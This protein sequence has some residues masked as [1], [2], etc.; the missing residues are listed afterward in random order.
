MQPESLAEIAAD[1]ARETG[2]LLRAMFATDLSVRSKGPADVVSEADHAAQELIER[3]LLEAR[4]DDGL[5]G[6]ED[7]ARTGSTGLRWVIDP[8]DGTANYLH[9]VPVWCVSIGCE[10]GDGPLAGAVYDAC[11]DE[12]FTAARGRG[13]RVDGEP[14][15]RPARAPSLAEAMVC[16]SLGRILDR[17]GHPRDFGSAA[18]ELAWTAAGRCDA[19]HHG[20]PQEWDVSAGT[21]LCREAGLEVSRAQGVTAGPAGLVE[22]LLAL[23]RSR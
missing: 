4:P 20:A 9:G 14:L 10:D 8:L 11:R 23:L 21:I 6:E 17:V 18:I 3:R 15:H 7:L 12:L 1:V 16:G 5:L 19:F 13:L 22:E 2:A